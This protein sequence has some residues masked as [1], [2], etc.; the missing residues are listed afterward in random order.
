MQEIEVR[1]QA[2][3]DAVDVNFDG[4]I[5]RIQP[6]PTKSRSGLAEFCTR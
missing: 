2:E 6:I 3:M 4:I 5:K 1:T